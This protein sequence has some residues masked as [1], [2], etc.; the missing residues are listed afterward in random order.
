MTFPCC[1]GH[2]KTQIYLDTGLVSRGRRQ[3]AYQDYWGIRKEDTYAG[4]GDIWNSTLVHSD[5]S[6]QV[7][8]K[9]FPLER[10]EN[11]SGK[12]ASETRPVKPILQ[13]NGT[14][15]TGL[16]KEDD[17]TA[18]WIGRGDPGEVVPDVY[19]FANGNVSEQ[20]QKVIPESRSPLF[21]REFRVDKPVRRARLFI[22]GLGL[23]ELRLNGEKVGQHVL[24]LPRQFSAN[25][26]FTIP[27]ILPQNSTRGL[28][29]LGIL[30]GNGWFNGQKK[31]WGW[32][33]SGTVRRVQ[34]F[35]WISNTL[36][37]ANHVWKPTATGNP[38]G[39]RL[40]LTACS[41]GNIMMPA[42]N[43]MAGINP[44]SMTVLGALSM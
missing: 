12:S 15:S 14:F 37:T 9:G 24:S 39:D 26:S 27:M 25:V 34:S 2:T 4:K 41:T 17:W 21:R 5:Q 19:T 31:Y 18:E 23:Y 22:V 8:Y 33:I 42:W 11:T 44:G 40:P 36:T 30:L 43:R 13:P 3:T 35:S 29:A 32:Q 38:P 16:L 28:N 1:P 7:I 10:T 20:V 6:T